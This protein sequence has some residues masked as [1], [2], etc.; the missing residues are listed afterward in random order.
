MLEAGAEAP[1][2]RLPDTHGAIKTLEEILSGGRALIA[3]Y[4][5]SC[6]VC[7][8]TLPFLDRFD[9][10]N[11]L[12]VFAISQDKAKNAKKFAGEFDLRMPILVD[13]ENYSASNA[14]RLTNVPSMFLVE[15]DGRISWTS[16]GFDRKALEELGH[17]VNASC[18]R[19]GEK[20]PDFRPG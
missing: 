12:R 17:K 18:F 4:K 10:G 14:Y 8:Y 3:F 15:P 1:D 11:H 13:D 16:M 7:Q 19:E 20:T 5:M 2:F 9:P 6:P